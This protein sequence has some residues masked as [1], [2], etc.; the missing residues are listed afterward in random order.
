MIKLIIKSL[1]FI[2]P[3]SFLIGFIAY[4]NLATPITFHSFRS[5]EALSVFGTNPL[6]SGPFYPNMK[7]TMK[8]EGDIAHGGKL[9]NLIEATWVTDG[10]GYRKVETNKIPEVVI[11]GDSFT[12]GTRLTQDETIAETLQR[13]TGL[14]TYPYAPRNINQYLAEERFQKTPPKIIILQSVEKLVSHVP[15]IIEKPKDT[16]FS[17]QPLLSLLK[18][19]DLALQFA[20]MSDRLEK[21]NFTNFLIS[22]ANNRITEFIVTRARDFSKP[23]EVTSVTIAKTEATKPAE[24]IKTLITP[25]MSKEE[26]IKIVGLNIAKDESMVFNAQSDEYF[27]PVSDRDVKDVAAKI[28]SY[29]DFFESKDIEFIFLPVPNKETI[30]YQKVRGGVY[31]D[32]LVRLITKLRENKVRV[33]DSF[34]A[35]EKAREN[36]P[37]KLLYFPDDTHWNGIGVDIITDLLKD[38][39]LTR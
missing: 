17:L 23:K 36:E 22:K 9:L 30:Y 25:E 26:V 13:K 11:I 12:A 8:E 18:Q 37:K 3:I 16:L 33:I 19:N 39:I 20:V 27:V 38:E 4:Q 34:T 21:S 24:L 28:I 6:L 1:I 31:Q 15:D 7:T 5:W 32:F 2:F 35:L 29:R 10:F 14:D